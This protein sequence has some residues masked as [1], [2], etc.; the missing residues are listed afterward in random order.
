[1]SDTTIALAVLTAIF[2]AMNIILIGVI[3]NLLYA[4]KDKKVVNIP[5]LSS[6]HLEGGSR[7]PSFNVMRT[8]ADNHAML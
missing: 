2:E 1:V 8:R 7:N 4:P 5:L 6:D 3:I